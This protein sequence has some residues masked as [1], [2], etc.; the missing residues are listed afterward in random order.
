[1]RFW[2]PTLGLIG[3]GTNPEGVEPDRNP[4]RVDLDLSLSQGWTQ[5]AHP[6]LGFD[7]MPLQGI[8]SFETVS[9][10]PHS[11]RTAGRNYFRES[12]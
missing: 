3:D 6:T 4:F 5:K 12:S 8:L 1:M 7:T 9:R 2:H 10:L 11:K